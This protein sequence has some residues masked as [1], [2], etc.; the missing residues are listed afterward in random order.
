MEIDEMNQ[1]ID[2]DDYNS[3][4]KY[5]EKRKK[6]THNNNKCITDCQLPGRTITH[7]LNNLRITEFE[8]PFCATEDWFDYKE[9]KIKYH[10]ICNHSEIDLIAWSHMDTTKFVP[11]N[12]QTCES[13]LAS[14]HGIKDLTDAINWAKKTHLD[15]NTRKRVLNCAWKIYKLQDENMPDIQKKIIEKYQK[16]A[17]ETWFETIYLGLNT[18]Y[19]EY[20]NEEEI[21]VDINRFLSN[22]KLIK[23]FLTTYINS[24]RKDWLTINFEEENIKLHF[25]NELKT[26]L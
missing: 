26:I 10:D 2:K 12:K 23:L 16:L 7:P 20:D 21:K 22:N 1:F 25:I 24:N 13:L 17:Q 5:P 14:M 8:G 4:K 11:S 6:N 18:E 19:S 3:Y 9:K 15:I